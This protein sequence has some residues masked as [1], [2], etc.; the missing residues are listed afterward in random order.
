M[1]APDYDA[2]LEDMRALYPEKFASEETIFS[3]LRPGDRIF[4]GT[5][6]GEPQ[7]LL[8]RLV[9]YVESHPKA[10][11]DAEILQ[12]VTLGVAP[13]ADEK[14]RSNFRHNAFF[15]GN[16][17]REAV[18]RGLAD[19][20]PVFLS[21]VPELINKKV[22][23]ID[24]ALV[25][26]SPPDRHGYMSLGLSVDITKVAAANAA[27]VVAQVN[28]YMPRVHG[29]TFIH[30]KDVDFLLP[31][32]EPLLE[33]TA[34]APDE[35]VQRIGAYVARIVQDGDTIQVGYGSIPNAILGRLFEKKHLGVHTELLSD[36][37]V[38]LMKAGVVDN[39]HK[40]I[41]R[42]KTVAAFCM[43]TRSTY[44][45]LDDNPSV[46]FRSID[47]TNNPLVIAGNAR[48]TAINSALQIDLTGQATAESIGRRFYSGIGGQADFMR[49]AV[50]SEGGKT[51]LALQ[52]TAQ[53]GTVSR[54][55]PLM[56]EGAGATLTRGDIHYVVTEYGIAHLHGKNI[57]E[58]AMDLI[59]VAHPDFR[60][61]LIAEA[62]QLGII[63]Q[64]QAFIPG[65]RGHYPEA[66]E[67]YRTTRTGLNLL[68]RP[69]KI[70]DEPL[71][72]D[73]FYSLSDQS[74]YLRFVSARRD[75]PHERLQEFV[76]IDYTME[77]V[78]LAV[79]PA[80]KKE[81]VIGVA[82]YNI[83]EKTHFAEAAVIVRDDYQNKGVGTELFSYL[84]QLA[85]K[86]G[87][88]GLTAEVLV[89]NTVM[90][91]LLV[92]LGFQIKKR[93]EGMFEMELD[94]R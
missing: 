53:G 86:Q 19:Y 47:Y 17:T 44:E 64:D 49:G 81:E 6:C 61:W 26:V 85:K 88:H 52:S 74:L 25:Q 60:P 37:I 67:T 46:E 91:H 35:V 16:N 11:F 80:E 78:I 1:S 79:L 58:R 4:V 42:G 76:V 84:I 20:T 72:K 10:F 18:N 71:L 36:G 82:Q 7:Y 83:D 12:V 63:Y 55:V 94:F 57:R 56:A 70:S 2:L 66:L 14:F 9:E 32:N 62:K 65:E 40:T 22:V 31:H 24:V 29:D 92:K 5:A 75:M 27:T 21:Q 89:R 73:F 41:D 34:T 3:H 45:F 51:I 33:Y 93:G 13:Y 59:A 77:M 69:V 54:I 43:G 15:I 23:P 38:A 48:M 50:L 28:K 87:L 68:L 39:S 30:I 8:K 90:L